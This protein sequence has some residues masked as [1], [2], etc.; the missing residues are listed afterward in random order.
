MQIVE[1]AVQGVK[2]FSPK[3]KAVLKSGYWVLQP[4]PPEL[5]NA[6]SKTLDL[7]KALL[8]PLADGSDASL[9][10]SPEQKAKAAL[11]LKTSDGTLYYLLK[12]MGGPAAL[13]RCP[14][15][16]SK[17]EK[18]S[19]D[20]SEISKILKS[21]FQLPSS[22]IFEQ[23]MVLEAAQLPSLRRNT[24]LNPEPPEK[25]PVQR[26]VEGDLLVP[27][28][29]I[30]PLF[31]DY[32]FW[33]GMVFGSVF[34]IGGMMLTRFR[35][36]ALFD[37]PSFAWSAFL[38][39]K[40]IEATKRKNFSD[41]SRARREQRKSL[42]DLKIPQ[43]STA[44]RSE[45]SGAGPKDR[46][47]EFKLF[48]KSAAE[49]WSVDLASAVSQLWQE[50]TTFYRELTGQTLSFSPPF[51][52]DG[53]GNLTGEIPSL[54]KSRLIYLALRLAA[55]ER[56]VSEVSLPFWVEGMLLPEDPQAESVLASRLKALGTRT[57]VLHCTVDSMYAAMADG[58]ATV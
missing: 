56:I 52:F 29:E 24:H 22:Q 34:L 3:F 14:V 46:L 48:F 41:R 33:L 17:I 13:H 57:Q 18:I 10:A 32:R 53:L 15:G 11:G 7:I 54:E 12:E 26:K 19:E 5:G 55:A 6:R 30:S 1:L 47:A 36:L 20:P 39:L 23:L 27:T 25:V 31:R 4:P 16:A 21:Q 42:M 58:I 44:L 49:Y 43:E 35:W 50:G 38:G 9:A 45:D 8:Y 37:I 28:T 40:Y 2:S 51:G